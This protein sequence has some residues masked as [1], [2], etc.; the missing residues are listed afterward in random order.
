MV[1]SVICTAL[2]QE[3]IRYADQALL[4]SLALQRL[5]MLSM[6]Q[7]TPSGQYYSGAVSSQGPAR[8]ARPALLASFAQ[9]CL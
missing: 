4:A 8:L 5:L 3:S 7:C 2:K 9:Q 6:V 1:Q